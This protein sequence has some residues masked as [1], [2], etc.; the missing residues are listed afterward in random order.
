MTTPQTLT[1]RFLLAPLLAVANLAA[2]TGSAGARERQP[3]LVPP[4]ICV[5]PRSPGAPAREQ[6]APASRFPGNSFVRSELFFGSPPGASHDRFHRFI[7]EVVTPCFPDGLTLLTGSGQFRAGP[8]S[9][10]VQETSFVLILLYPRDTWPESNAKIEAI[11]A[12]YKEHF[13]QQS[14]LRVDDHH[15]VRVDF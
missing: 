10:I 6:A 2:H 15:T 4:A 8:G 7:D 5:T 12:L 14:V 3:A 13:R 9:P 11:R 1:V